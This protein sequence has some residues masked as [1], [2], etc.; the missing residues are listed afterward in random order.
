MDW[1]TT[2]C[3]NSHTYCTNVNWVFKWWILTQFKYPVIQLQSASIGWWWKLGINI[4]RLAQPTT[5]LH[6]EISWEDRVLAS[7]DGSSWHWATNP[8]GLHQES[9]RTSL[10]VAAIVIHQRILVDSWW[11]P[12]GLLME[13]WWSP[14]GSGVHQE[15][16]SSPLKSEQDSTY[17]PE[18]LLMDSTK[19]KLI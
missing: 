10:K 11:T 2:G 19:A 12:D 6:R 15:S 4:F 8:D 17:S 14:S 5:L 1:T 13:S 7:Q 16:W 9:I 3:L 18:G